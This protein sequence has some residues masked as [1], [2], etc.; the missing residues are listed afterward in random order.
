MPI[1][2]PPPHDVPGFHSGKPPK[3]SP[4]PWP[5]EVRELVRR[6]GA[7]ESRERASADAPAHQA[8]GLRQRTADAVQAVLDALTAGSLD[9]GVRLADAALR[10][11]PDNEVLLVN[12]GMAL[13]DLGRI[14]EAIVRLRAGFDRHPAPDTAVALG[15][16][17]LRANDSVNGES[18]LRL[19]LD[20]DPQN[21][22]ARRNLGVALLMRGDASGATAFLAPLAEECP[23]D[24]AV[25]CGYGHAL[26]ASGQ[27][28]QADR[29]FARAIG[30]DPG[31]DA[32]EVART[33]RSRIAHLL[34][35]AAAG[36][37]SLRFDA[38]AYL[39]D[40]LETY[41]SASQP[42]AFAVF[43]EVALIGRHGFHV[44][45]ASRNYA[46]RTLPGRRFSG[47]HLSCFLYAGVKTF[48]PDQDAGFDLS[49]EYEAALVLAGTAKPAP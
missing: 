43:R 23:D 46:L 38:V 39:A 29:V 30:V 21:T 12:S 44:N 31:T 17:Y 37:L 11:D 22:H 35:R 10:M 33:Q 27:P 25:L 13:S 20:A 24:Q 42:R 2:T 41:A 36:G 6:L 32:A 47:L 26:L 16:A 40:A 48:M 18:W 5:S 28:E 8:E 34:F 19:A 49:K 7:A 15:V 14:P 3:E 9:E 4:G 1:P 45:D